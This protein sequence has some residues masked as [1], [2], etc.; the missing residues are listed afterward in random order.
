MSNAIKLKTPFNQ[1][2]LYFGTLLIIGSSAF[3]IE[4]VPSTFTLIPP[5]RNGSSDK[6]AV[7]NFFCR[8]G[9]GCKN[10]GVIVFKSN[11]DGNSKQKTAERE[12]MLRVS[13]NPGGGLEDVS[14]NSLYGGQSANLGSPLTGLESGLT[15]GGCVGDLNGDG[16]SDI[17]AVNKPEHA[18]IKSN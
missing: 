8:A 16:Y 10:D 1:A 17:V 11:T 3:A 7:G 15:I 9:L 2:L 5:I 18:R 13:S 14:F 4:F 6:V 12:I